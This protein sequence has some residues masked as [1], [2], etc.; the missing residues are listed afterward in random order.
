MHEIVT[1]IYA[2]KS[3]VFIARLDGNI[4]SIKLPQSWYKFSSKVKPYSFEIRNLE[5]IVSGMQA[6]KGVLFV[7]TPNFLINFDLE[8]NYLSNEGFKKYVADCTKIK[9]DYQNKI[10]FAA[11]EER[12]IVALK[13]S[14][15]RNPL[16]LTD[17]KLDISGKQY[18]SE[19]DVFDNTVYLAIRNLGIIRIDYNENEFKKPKI[20]RT[21]RKI[22]LEDPQDVKYNKHN[23]Y[24]YIADSD[25]GFLL[26]S[27]INNQLVFSQ[28]LPNFDSP[29][30]IILHYQNALIQGSKGLYMFNKADE[31][32]QVIFDYKIG[33]S[34]KYYNKFIY[35]NDG[36][37]N[38]LILG[39][40]DTLDLND[41]GYNPFKNIFS[42]SKKEIRRIK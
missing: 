36:F 39:K 5:K 20:T 9:I 21:V 26:L 17:M 12:G 11:S 14:N 38:L 41:T 15:P 24:L 18:I 28:Q 33:A 8:D 31:T 32:I 19:M 42:Y 23:K 4:T 35:Y 30:K 16:F 13:I 3:S 34:T 10:L 37:L 6:L 29:K 1:T 40:S 27:T 22:K 2:Y 7:A 25:Q